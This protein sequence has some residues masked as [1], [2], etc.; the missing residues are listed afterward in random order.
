MSLL[1]LNPA[2]QQGSISG[3]AVI[4]VQSGTLPVVIA[5]SLGST[6]FANVT[7]SG[8]S[9]SGTLHRLVVAFSGD[10]IQI[11]QGGLIANVTDDSEYEVDNTENALTTNAYLYGQ[12]PISGRMGALQTTASGQEISGIFHKLVV[13]FSGDIARIG[14]GGVVAGV[15]DD[16]LYTLNAGTNGLTAYSYIYGHT[17][18]SGRMAGLQLTE[19][20]QEIS[21]IH[22]KL[23]VAFSGDIVQIG[24]AGAAGIL[25]NIGND[26]S[27]ELQNDDNGLTTYGFMYGQMPIS[28]QMGA[29]QTTASGQGISGIFHKLV[30]TF[31]GDSIIGSVSG[32]MV[33]VS[34]QPVN[35]SGNVVDIGAAGNVAVVNS[36]LTDNMTNS[37]NALGVRANLMGYNESVNDWARIR[38]TQSGQGISGTAH[39]LV[40][41]FSG[42]SVF[43]HGSTLITN[44]MRQVTNASGGVVLSSGS[45]FSVTINNESGNAPV[46]IGGTGAQAPFSGKGLHVYGG[47]SISLKIDSVDDIRVFGET[48][49][50]FVSWLG[51]VK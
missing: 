14:Q 31:S 32:N 11:G 22:H 20:G 28:G 51:I 29:L 41:A 8:Q 48:S 12:M 40:V 42:D 23:V 16:A 17:P 50:Q 9:I 49:G 35:V 15:Q 7:A 4:V 36:T 13:T 30:V 47:G 25:A 39:K 43:E 46:W 34:G 27:Y 19:S 24:E 3:A 26:A 21:G 1:N 2:N 18:L 6:E 37:D 45:I 44:P 5:R 38:I 10:I 33:S